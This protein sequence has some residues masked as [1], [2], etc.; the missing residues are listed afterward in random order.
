MFQHIAACESPPTQPVIYL[1]EVSVY[2]VDEKLLGRCSAV[3]SAAETEADAALIHLSS[4]HL[5][6]RL[7]SFILLHFLSSVE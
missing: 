1:S 6:F 5:L 4:P 3:R 7:K 2:K